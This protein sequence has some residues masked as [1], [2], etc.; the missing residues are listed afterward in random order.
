MNVK[1]LSAIGIS[2]LLMAGGVWSAS[3][4]STSGY[5]LFKTSMKNIHN[6]NSFT[7][8]VQ[9]SLSDNGKEIYQV[10]SVSQQDIKS[11]TSNSSFTINNGNAA[12]KVEF[13]SND[14]QE[15][16][17]S[18]DDESYY[19]EQENEGK[20]EGKKENQKEEELTPQMQKDI[21]GIFDSLTKNYQD[22][23]TIEKV[24]K[25]KYRIAA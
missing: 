12:K 4:S 15:I 21:E 24:G 22:S 11:D 10:S 5:D 3:A 7:A 2:G 13:F 18:S 23:I 1:V 9:A 19:V 17:K 20:D 25:W 14:Q 16:V 6:L 8:D